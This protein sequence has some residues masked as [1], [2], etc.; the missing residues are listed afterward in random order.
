MQANLTNPLAVAM[1][2]ELDAPGRGTIEFEKFDPPIHSDLPLAPARLTS[3]PAERELTGHVVINAVDLESA[4]SLLANFALKNVDALKGAIEQL[5]QSDSIRWIKFAS[6]HE[7]IQVFSKKLR[8]TARKKLRFERLDPVYPLGHVN[9]IGRE[10]RGDVVIDVVSLLDRH[11]SLERLPVVIV[12]HNGGSR[13][14]L[15]VPVGASVAS[16]VAGVTPSLIV[17]GA[18][19]G[20]RFIDPDV[21]LHAS[22]E[23]VFHVMERIERK[24]DPC[25]RCG[26][27]V[28][29][30]P[31]GCHPA[32]LLDAV[33][34]R[35]ADRSDRFGLD[36]CL[37]CGLCTR[38]CPSRLPLTEEFARARRDPLR[39]IGGER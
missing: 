3:D 28:E 25:I 15:D 29:V 30:C 19:L 2:A 26:W 38:I 34:H 5:S 18:A 6:T 4:S 9:I 21:R 36:A 32:E 35:N 23:L 10:L 12:D 39:T 37:E 8:D 11:Q 16:L 14:F 1:L 7:P 31:V 17:A 22:G 33:A 27:C 20:E 13:R 24:P